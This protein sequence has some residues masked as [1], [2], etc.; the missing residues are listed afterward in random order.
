VSSQRVD[1]GGAAGY[2]ALPLAAAGYEVHLVDPMPL[3]VDQAAHASRVAPTPL[4]SVQVGDARAL[5][6][7]D[8]ADG[9]MAGYLRDPE[10]AMSVARD[11]H[12]GIHANPDRIPGWFASDIDGLLDDLPTRGRVLEAIRRVEREPALLGAS[13]HLLVAAH[14]PAGPFASSSSTP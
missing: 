1:V 9:L 12:S 14:L 2:C 11:V 13:A 7:D 5:P 8:A 4:A 10:F 3:H 6:F